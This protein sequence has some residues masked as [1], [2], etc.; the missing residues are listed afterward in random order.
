MTEDESTITTDERG[1]QIERT[2][3]ASPE[4]V[5][6]AWTEAEHFARWYG[7]KG[8]S[9]P[10]CDFDFRVGGEYS[11]VMRSPDGWEMRNFRRVQGD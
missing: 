5:W 7:P 3:D 4:L 10:N 9:V 2:F 6:Q 1:V 8:F 11:L